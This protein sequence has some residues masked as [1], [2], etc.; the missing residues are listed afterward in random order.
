MFKSL[1]HEVRTLEVN[2][3]TLSRDDDKRIT[4]NG[5]ASLARDHYMAP[6]EP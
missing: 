6:D 2:K 5:I 1:R 3:S 4:I